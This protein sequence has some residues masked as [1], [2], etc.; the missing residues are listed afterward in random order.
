[1]FINP[2]T[3]NP[4]YYNKNFAQAGE[5]LYAATNFFNSNE[6]TTLSLYKGNKNLEVLWTENM[7]NQNHF[8]NGN[9]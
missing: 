5:N 2:F 7:D 4:Y 1:M 9:T 8:N 6:S 3:T